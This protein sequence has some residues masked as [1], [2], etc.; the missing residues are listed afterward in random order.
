MTEEH[1]AILL[2]VK[3]WNDAT[4]W[5]R[6]A[7]SKE[8]EGRSFEGAAGMD[9]KDIDLLKFFTKIERIQSYAEAAFWVS[10]VNLAALVWVLVLLTL[11]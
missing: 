5:Q 10:A 6:G 8:M 11:K 2:E 7:F 9:W 4:P 1:T 3:S